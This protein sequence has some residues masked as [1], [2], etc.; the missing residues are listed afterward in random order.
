V[1]G[2][3]EG[4]LRVDVEIGHG[5]RIERLPVVVKRPRGEL[6]DEV[7]LRVGLVDHRGRHAGQGGD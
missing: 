5:H 4:A 3:A 7:P 2:E 6:G 1:R